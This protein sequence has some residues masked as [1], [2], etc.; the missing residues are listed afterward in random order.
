MSYH[1]GTHRFLSLLLFLLSVYPSTA[2]D[3]PR[4]ATFRTDSQMVLVPV[5][6]TDH[7][8][9]TVNGLR[10]E[11]F[12]ILDDRMPQ[13]IV[14]FSSEDA[15]CS[16]GLILDV[17][18]SM[19]DT[20]YAAKEVARAFLAESNPEDEFFL[21][22]VSTRPEAIS[23]FTTDT[24][25]LLNSV[26][27]IRPD[28]DTALIDTV[29][30]GLHRMH[31]AKRP[32]RALLV[33]SD[34][35]DNHS[36]YSKGELMSVAVEADVQIYTI[37][38][39]N[40]PAGKKPIELMEERRGRI[41]LEDLAEKTGGLHFRAVSMTDANQVAAKVARALRNE[42]VIGFQIQT[43]A[44]SGKWHRI[45]VKADVPD[46]SVYARNGYYSR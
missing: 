33:L 46:T 2:Q 10:A 38:I 28:G 23:G 13:R 44:E 24:A 26:Q 17:S 19:R 42:Y 11:N 37:L 31:A 4:P 18:G 27:R 25:T 30:A 12:T 32:R 9:K 36:R 39:D 35:M 5:T 15:P 3:K 43:P 40:T 29:Y 7:K 22:T 14:S 34:G 45:R 16:V 6:V 8:G 1:P 21:M 20:L 41:L